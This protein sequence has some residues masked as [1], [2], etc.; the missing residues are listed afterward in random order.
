[1]GVNFLIPWLLAGAALI[2]VPIIIHLILR[3]KPKHLLFPAFRYLQQRSRTNLQKLRLRHL[4]LLA[5]RMLLIVFMCLA[6]AR[7]L[8]VGGPEQLAM[9]HPLAVVLVF[10]TSPSMEYEHEG[11]SRLDEAKEIGLRFVEYLPTDSE[12]AIVDTGEPGVRFTTPRDAASLI[13]TRRIRPLSQPVT[14]SLEEVYRHLEKEPPELPVVLVVFSDRTAASWNQDAVNAVV[15]A[16]RQRAVSKLGSEIPSLYL[17]LGPTEPRNAAITGL[18]LKRAEQDQPTALEDLP[19]GTSN[20]RPILQATVQI[21]G[22]S[23]DTDVTLWMDGR[24]VDTKRLVVSC[25]PGQTVTEAVTFAPLDFPAE[26]PNQ[27][28][29]GEVRLKSRDLL[30]ADNL[31]YYTLSVQERKVLIIAD[32]PN[33]AR[34][35]QDVLESIDQLPLTCV[36]SAPRDIPATLHPDQYVFVCL[37]NVAEPSPVL[38]ENLTR[39]LNAGGSI[40]IMP[41]EDCRADAYN[42]PEALAVMPARLVRK[43]DVPSPGSALAPT[44]YNHPILAPFKFWERPRLPGL[45]FRHWQVEVLSGASQVVLPFSHRS[46]DKPEPEPA[47]LERVPDPNK[48]QGRVVLFTT[49]LYRPRKDWN[50][51]WDSWTC[52]GLTFATAR[53]LVGARDERQNFTLKDD[54]RFWLPQGSGATAYSLSGPET[55]VG[56]IRPGQSQLVITEAQRPGNYRVAIGDSWQ[57]HFSVNLPAL[58]TV[59]AQQRPSVADLE[60]LLGANTVFQADQAP[61]LSELTRDKLG[62]RPSVELLPW[63]MVAVLLVL[64]L[65]G[66]VANRFYRQERQ[67][68]ENTA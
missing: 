47:I 22:A 55:A 46:E 41:G 61:E 17:D 54:V 59:L 14:A 25:Q 68:V 63:L 64:A 26:P 16:A 58:E 67:P 2:A 31:R 39:Y 57:R 56:E 30:P 52:V 13:R 11:Q 35:W 32:R 43:A 27:V 40:I 51:I 3:R 29:Q 7:P 23:V 33:E 8:L 53:H 6:L 12:V 10:D 44:D 42:S 65:E 20:R 48:P 60:G 34:D 24:L 49:P 66:F 45:V 37:V 36:A 4:L 62:Q 50:T 5:L 9:D 28:H 38:W 21:T 19:T 1:M 18:S 15:K